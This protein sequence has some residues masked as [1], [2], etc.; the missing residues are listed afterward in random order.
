MVWKLVYS[1]GCDPTGDFI[2]SG[3]DM[4]KLIAGVIETEYGC[5]GELN[6][7]VNYLKS[8]YSDMNRINELWYTEDI[9]WSQVVQGNIRSLDHMDNIELMWIELPDDKKT[10][11]SKSSIVP[12]NRPAWVL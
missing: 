5:A 1:E 6:D 8:P 10:E 7:L 3:S 4:A 11:S 12:T 9:D 2:E